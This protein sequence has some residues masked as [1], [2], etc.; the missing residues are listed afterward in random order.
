MIYDRTEKSAAIG[1][2][3]KFSAIKNEKEVL[4]GP[5]MRFKI[6]KVAKNAELDFNYLR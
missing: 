4:I 1:P 2:I 5:Y 6:L 3:H